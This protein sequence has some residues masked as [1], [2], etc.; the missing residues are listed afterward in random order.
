[1]IATNINKPYLIF[2]YIEI[3][4]EVIGMGLGI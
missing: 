4:Y 2:W 1:M 3:F